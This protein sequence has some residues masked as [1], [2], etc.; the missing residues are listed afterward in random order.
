VHAHAFH[1]KIA[2]KATRQLDDYYGVRPFGDGTLEHLLKSEE[3][4][5]IDRVVIHC[6]ATVPEQVVPAN[7]WAIALQKL[8][9]RVIAFGTVH[10]ESELWES[11]LD[12]LEGAG[13]RG[14]K[15]HPDFQ[16]IWLDDP[17]LDPIFEAAAGR[18]II[19]FHVG[20]ERAPE[21]NF[22]CPQKIANIK[23]RFPKLEMIAAHFGGLY[24]WDYVP[25]MLG[26]L[27]IYVDT[28]SAVP[29]MSEC[30]LAEIKKAIPRERWLF[31]TDY[32]L[33]SPVECIERQQQKLGLSSREMDELLN[34][35][36]R[37][38][39]A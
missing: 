1:P 6:A 36:C 38:F 11:E 16:Q 14:L 31:G 34:N 15:L 2:Q 30:Q 19:M 29:F 24:H 20:D 32:P 12:R 25:Q 8:D 26:G 37:L 4:A 35:G 10:T 7:D 23:R 28:S 13:I 17:K 18:F 33:Y 9:K 22:S 5:G 39:G 27:D 3:E 21:D